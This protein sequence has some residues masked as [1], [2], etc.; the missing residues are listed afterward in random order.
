MLSSL[1]IT[2][3]YSVSYK[4]HLFARHLQED[5]NLFKNT[6]RHHYTIRCGTIR[7]DRHIKSSNRGHD[8]PLALRHTPCI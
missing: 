2:R 3:A 4:I 6:R 1:D 5:E 7:P 8:R